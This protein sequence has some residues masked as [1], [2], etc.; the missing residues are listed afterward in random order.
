MSRVSGRA[1]GW[2]SS[3]AR[4]EHTAAPLPRRR[5]RVNVRAQ[6]TLVA[7]VSSARGE[8]VTCRH[9]IFTSFSLAAVSRQKASC[10]G[11]KTCLPS[12]SSSTTAVFLDTTSTQQS[13]AGFLSPRTLT[14]SNSHT[15]CP[16]S[17]PRSPNL[18]AQG[19][20]TQEE[21]PY[22]TFRTIKEAIMAAPPAF[23][24][25]AR[26]KGN[27]PSTPRLALTSSGSLRPNYFTSAARPC[28]QPSARPPPMPLPWAPPP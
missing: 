28:L 5:R 4:C 10:Y 20:N 16:S 27:P 26:V 11:S 13:R 15:C 22:T 6:R 2:Q 18:K 21:N 14:A 9:N 25:P 24:T 23:D 7:K 1:Q 17:A 3:A 8:A 12:R 19:W